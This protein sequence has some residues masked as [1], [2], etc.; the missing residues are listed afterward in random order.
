MQMTKEELGEALSHTG[1]DKFEFSKTSVKKSD[2]EAMI[3]MGA[4]CDGYALDAAC[5]FLDDCISAFGTVTFNGIAGVFGKKGEGETFS[6]EIGNGEDGVFNIKNG[7]V[8]LVSA[9]FGKACDFKDGVIDT[10]VQHIAVYASDA[11]V[12]A[13]IASV[14][15]AN[16]SGSVTA[17]YGRDGLSFEA[18]ILKEDGKEVYTKNAKSNE[19]YT[20]ITTTVEEEK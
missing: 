1:A 5:D 6:V 16:G 12:A 2:T 15:Y 4:L 3:D 14:G 13:V 17:L 10:D 20:P 18:V 7:Y 9:D 11:R 8:A 19:L